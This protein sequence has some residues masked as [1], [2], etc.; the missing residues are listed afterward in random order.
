MGFEFKGVEGLPLFKSTHEFSF[1][2][3]TDGVFFEIDGEFLITESIVSI[4][5]SL[6]FTCLSAF[7]T[8]ELKVVIEL[9]I[10]F[11]IDGEAA[12]VFMISITGVL[13][14]E[15]TCSTLHVLFENL[16]M[17]LIIEPLFRLVV[18]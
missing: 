16:L 12:T 3:L 2:N 6:S 5:V 10:G 1:L 18:F 8:D 7:L 14:V 17:N 11:E 4:K 15:T 13:S 9:L